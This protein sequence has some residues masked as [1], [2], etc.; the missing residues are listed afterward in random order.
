M[1]AS[2]S[3]FKST[4]LINFEGKVTHGRWVPPKFLSSSQYYRYRVPA[5]LA[6]RPDLISHEEYGAVEYYWAIIIYN[7]PEN[8]LNWPAADE[9]ILL[10][11]LSQLV[12][13]Y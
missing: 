7:S 13:E 4:P 1:A 2:N 8:P 9:M 12:S 5:R 10:P 11:D 3:R 6:G